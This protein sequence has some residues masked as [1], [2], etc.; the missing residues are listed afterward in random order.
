MA[1]NLL[2]KLDRDPGGA[3]RY[4]ASLYAFGASHEQAAQKLAEQFHVRAPT[5]RTTGEWRRNDPQ[6]RQMIEA[7]EAAKADVGADADPADVLANVPAPVD[8]CELATA[9]FDLHEDYPAWSRLSHRAFNDPDMDDDLAWNILLEDHADDGAFE[10][11]CEAAADG[12]DPLGYEIAKHYAKRAP[13]AALP[14]VA[15]PYAHYFA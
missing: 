1:D 15:Q 5:S 2:D 8:P 10:A 13:D 12:W 6:L 9:I 14:E 3:R 7:L 4:L 11:A